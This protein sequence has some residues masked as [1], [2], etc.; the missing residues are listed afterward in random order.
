MLISRRAFI[1]GSLSPLVF[2]A[3]PA[4]AQDSCG[5]ETEIVALAD[6]V[7]AN[8]SKMPKLQSRR[9]GAVSAY[10]KIR[11]QNLGSDQVESLVAPLAVANV[12]GARELLDSWR[13]SAKGLEGMLADNPEAEKALLTPGTGFSM[14]RAAVL[15]GEIPLLFDKL[16]SLP[17]QDRWRIE[18][19]LAEALVDIEDESAQA[20][21]AEAQ[22]RSLLAAAAGLIA[23]HADA[24]AWQAFIDGVADK[25]K[26]ETLIRQFYW[27]P[28]L[29]GLPAFPRA[30]AA[31]AQGEMMRALFHQTAMAS[32]R[33]PERDYLSTYLNQTGDFAGVGAAATALNDLLRDGATI[34]METAWLV[35][36][37]ALK[38]A[39]ATK[40][41][42]DGQLKA[43]PF[44]GTRFGGTNV[45]DAIDT[46]LAVEAFK[47]TAAGGGPAPDMV[48]G[49]SKDFVVQLPAWRDAADAIGKGAD[50]APFRA[51]GQR[52]AIVANLLFASGRQT[53]LAKFLTGTV[54]NTDSIRLAE[55]YA[56]ALDRRCA[57][58]L[59][60]PGQALTM[61]D[62]PLFRFDPQT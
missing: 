2:H 42:L 57:G 36:F 62:A 43:I 19:R 23:T 21:A 25:T 49:A 15:T 4:S 48:E 13:I 52:L 34:D 33:T 55:I 26:A 41:E 31:D 46:M 24:K 38:D 29:R 35:A 1:L 5:A 7:L 37:E 14:L 10:L 12:D 45:R 6:Y 58:H 60:F 30:A 28:A 40:S 27:F 9:N 16:A 44:S 59:N 18:T 8:R 11:Y 39:S 22:S 56:D 51:S 54:P 53:D 17:E 61:P 3:L 32:A 50:L 20:I 47:A